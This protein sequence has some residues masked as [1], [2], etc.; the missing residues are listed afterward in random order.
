MTSGTHRFTA[1]TSG[2]YRIEAMLPG[3]RTHGVAEVWLQGSDDS[4]DN[5]LASEQLVD[6]RLIEPTS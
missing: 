5:G 3:T 2:W 4:R 1:T 6:F